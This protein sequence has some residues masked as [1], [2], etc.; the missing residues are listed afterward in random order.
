[1]GRLIRNALD[2]THPYHEFLDAHVKEEFGTIAAADGQ[3]LNYRLTRP[4]GLQAGKRYPVVVDVYGGPHN[5]Y[6][7]KE[8]MGGGFF[9][10]AAE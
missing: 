2:A 9:R 4:A 10:E 5:Q 8:W 1:M 3:Q 6:V 7:K